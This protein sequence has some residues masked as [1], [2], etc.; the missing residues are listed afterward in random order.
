M[1][2]WEEIN[3]PPP[4]PKQPKQPRQRYKTLPLLPRADARFNT[5]FKRAAR[6]LTP[7]QQSLVVS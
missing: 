7:P 2:D 6:R 3:P 5:R 1:R 4:K